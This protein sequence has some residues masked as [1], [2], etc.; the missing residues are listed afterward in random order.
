MSITK[1]SF[2]TLDELISA[3]MHRG[4]FRFRSI[5]SSVRVDSY[6]KILNV[7]HL[8]NLNRP[9]DYIRATE[10]YTRTGELSRF[11]HHLDIVC[12]IK[13]YTAIRIEG[14]VNEFLPSAL[15]DYGYHRLIRNKGI[16]DYQYIL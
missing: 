10:R 16:V 4:V 12:S 6:A 2:G 9:S 7:M 13:K 1:Q 14:V 8:Q 5:Y 15:E 11:L 3:G